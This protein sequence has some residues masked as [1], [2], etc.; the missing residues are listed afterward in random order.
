[1]K[2]A[3][4][5][6]IIV[7]NFAHAKTININV[8]SAY[9]S[10]EFTIDDIE[11]ESIDTVKFSN[12]ICIAF[13]KAPVGG[14][15]G[16]E[17]HGGLT[18]I[19]STSIVRFDGERS[20][21]KRE[22]RR[23]WEFIYN[24]RKIVKNWYKTE[25]IPQTEYPADT[26]GYQRN[27]S[28]HFRHPAFYFF[29]V[30]GPEGGTPFDDVD[31][32]MTDDYKAI[33]YIKALNGTNLKLQIY[34]YS[35]RLEK[36]GPDQ[37][38]CQ[39]I[40]NFS[41]RWAVDSA[42]NG[43]FK[44]NIVYDT[45]DVQSHFQNAPILNKH[46]FSSDEEVVEVKLLSPATD[47][48]A[49]TK[50]ENS[51]VIYYTLQENDADYWKDS[52]VYRVRTTKKTYD[53]FTFLNIKLNESCAL[54]DTL[55]ININDRVLEIKDGIIVTDDTIFTLPCNVFNNDDIEV[56]SNFRIITNAEHGRVT[57]KDDGTVHYRVTQDSISMFYGW[58][59]PDF[60]YLRYS[61]F[62]S[63]GK[64]GTAKLTFIALFD[65]TSIINP[66]SIHSKAT[67]IKASNNL[68]TLNFG[69]ELKTQSVTLY[70]IDGRALETHSVNSNL[71]QITVRP[72]SPLGAGVYLLSV[73][74][75]NETMKKRITI[76]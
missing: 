7:I 59:R 23:D 68:I 45:L 24:H 27:D 51:E 17:A 74:C 56:P 46:E 26:L 14:G 6:F 67:S 19:D 34:D 30:W 61:V 50:V 49:T 11:Y 8:D 13:F 72:N 3:L 10:G 43:N 65:E 21:S 48:N 52:L 32:G 40:D 4:L 38:W 75:D 37:Y 41:F 54:D 47:R 62:S 55:T 66:E 2:N 71:S 76:K 73:H 70:S 20:R 57:L 12:G 63:D 5:I 58:K 39:S 28:I 31:E 15:M 42:G 9:S 33:C 25:T 18:V 22:T 35:K 36:L 60:D 1:M 44:H 16:L 53:V 69:T 29:E 64:I